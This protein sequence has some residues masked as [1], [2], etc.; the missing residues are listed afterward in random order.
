MII[1]KSD[2]A[3]RVFLADWNRMKESLKDQIASRGY[4]VSNEMR[5]AAI[6]TLRGQRHGRVYRVPYTK[7][8]Y[9]ASAP[10]EAPAN[11]TGIYRLSWHPSTYATE[12]GSGEITVISQVGS[13]YRVRGGH[14]LGDILENG[15]SRMAPRPHADAIREKSEKSAMRIYSEPYVL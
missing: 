14:N 15:T 4:R 10:G 11:R 13:D 9:T 3:A 1:T 5:N 6:L 2:A 8:Y 12:L 7:R